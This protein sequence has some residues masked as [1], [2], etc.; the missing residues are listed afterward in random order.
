MA[1]SKRAPV[2]KKP[3]A[4]REPF[5][6]DLT[7]HAKQSIAAL[8]VGSLG[9]FFV[10]SLLTYAGMVGSWTKI[11]LEYL[12]GAGSYLAPVAC[13]FFVY[14]F[15]N[16]REDSRV[17]GSKIFGIIILFLALVGGFE[18]YEAT[19]G[20]LLGLGVKWPLEFLMG[21][22]ASGVFLGALFLIG[23]FLTFNIGLGLPAFMRSRPLPQDDGFDTSDIDNL[24]LPPED[25]DQATADVDTEADEPVP[26]D[27]KRTFTDRIGITGDGGKT[28]SEEF[29]VSNFVG[30]YDPPPLS[31]LS[32]D[33]GKAKTGDVKANANTIKRVLKEFG[34]DVEMDK[35]EIGPTVTQYALKPAQG[36]KI[37]RILGLQKELELN[38]ASGTIRIEAP[39]AGKSLVGIE[40]PN[41]ERA[42]IGLASMLTSPEYTD[43]PK[44]LLVALGKD[45]TGR[46]QFGN[47]ARMPHA[48][49]AGTTGSG[50]SVAIHNLIISLL[51]RNSPEQLR[52]LLVD[53]KLVELTL[54]DGIPH[55]MV[56]VITEAKRALRAFKWGVN[57]MERRY[58]VLQERGVQNVE[59]YHDKIYH[60][61]KK[62]WEAG[63]SDEEE[64][65]ELPES[66]PYIVI[67]IDELN[68]LMQ[69][70]PRDF[71]ALIVRLA[72]KSRAVGIHLILATQRPSVNVITGT[73]KA[74]IPTRIALQVRQQ[75]DS[76]TILDQIGAEQLIGK[77]DMLFLSNESGKPTRL[78]SAFVT[79]E[80]IK[81]VVNYLKKQSDAYGLDHIDL[82]GANPTEGGIFAGDVSG[83]GDDADDELFI[84]AKAV[85]LEAGKA[86][87][88]LL[89]RRLRIGYG[90][91]A[92]I[93]DV[94]EEHGVIGPAD[95]AKPREILIGRGGNDTNADVAE[96]DDGGDNRY[97]S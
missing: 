68:D 24:Q 62:V 45:I 21:S 87:T 8:A 74:N 3:S 11:V 6:N 83:S 28:G 52:F 29:F 32:K 61:A 7:P 16:P 41:I 51:F 70:Y 1:K 69:A 67:V 92:R 55:L 78:Q 23:V 33:K 38:L 14:A 47:V 82:D 54:Y 94:L 22:L 30:S 18:L 71:E 20:G 15:M 2:K 50:K 10:L 27:K 37:S 97:M 66:L 42:S 49:I 46:V 26:A 25:D 86:S 85:V 84:D 31:L 90:R 89:Q 60:P 95:G 93:M 57:E 12:F 19:A 56:P 40:V 35:V 88:S 64:K 36:V 81:N 17:S 91:A 48:L 59:A 72:Q 79:E 76:R 5:F 39:I 13:G 53:P 58:G 80:E 9:V 77:G 96:E 43:S 73:I 65:L 44:P 34:I 63:G 4:P 75:V